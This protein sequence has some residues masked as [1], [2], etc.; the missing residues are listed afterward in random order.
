VRRREHGLA[1][2]LIRALYAEFSGGD[3]SVRAVVERLAGADRAAPSEA[4]LREEGEGWKVA[5]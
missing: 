1:A 5:A 4:H 2:R 3:G